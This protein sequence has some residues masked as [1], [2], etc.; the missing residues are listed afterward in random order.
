MKRELGHPIFIKALLK[1]FVDG[2][3]KMKLCEPFQRQSS[4]HNKFVKLL[5]N[6]EICL[7]MW[8]QL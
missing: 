3:S 7:K 6:P 5:Y 8:L 1:L 4:G 2:R